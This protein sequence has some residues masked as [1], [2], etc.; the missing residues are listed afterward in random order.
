MGLEDSFP[1]G[2]GPCSGQTA[3]FGGEYSYSEQ[4]LP[5]FF[6]RLTRVFPKIGVPQDG[7]FFSWK[8]LLIHG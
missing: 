6:T 5:G 4:N 2:D 1:F 7:W 3:N 8:T